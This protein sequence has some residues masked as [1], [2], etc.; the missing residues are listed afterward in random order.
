[1][2]LTSKA[3]VIL[4]LLVTLVSSQSQ[5]HWTSTVNK[6]SNNANNNYNYVRGNAHQITQNTNANFNK[7]RD[8]A[9]PY[10]MQ[11]LRGSIREL[12]YRLRDQTPNMIN[13]LSDPGVARALFLGGTA[14]SACPRK[15]P[16]SKSHF[17]TMFAWLLSSSFILTTDF[18]WIKLKSFIFE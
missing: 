17:Q 6:I 10:T 9:F 2:I 3:V 8:W 15:R 12:P 16:Q 11:D 1:M 18:T 14:V 13:F 5:S 7:L 4:D